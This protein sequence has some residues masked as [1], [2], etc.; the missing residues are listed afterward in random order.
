MSAVPP[1]AP[2]AAPYR[3]ADTL[4]P[5]APALGVV[6]VVFLLA[7]AGVAALAHLAPDRGHGHARAV[8]A[9]GARAAVQLAAVSWV[10]GWVVGAV[11]TL[12]A[13]LVLMYAVATRTAGR[14]V[15]GNRT[16]WWAGLPIA[17]GVVPVVLVLL[18]GGLVPLR[19]ITLIPVTGILIGGALTASTLAGRNA[20][21]A[22]RTRHGEVEAALALGFLERDARMEIARPAASGGLIP[23]LDQTRTV[24][25]VTLPGAFVGMLLGGASPVQAG[26]VQLFVLVALLLVEVIAVSVMLELIARGRLHR[27]GAGGGGGRPAAGR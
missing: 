11:P 17:A 3:A 23:A 4:L 27:D 15:T 7:A 5:V 16:W 2:S 26:A 6:L 19:G 12:L 25:L 10:I 22:L 1:V 18:L 14:R 21:D 8:L 20:L 24:G 9:A 13:F